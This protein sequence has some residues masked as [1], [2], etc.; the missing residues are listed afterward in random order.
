MTFL[1]LVVVVL[2]IPLS[3]EKQRN[4][5]GSGAINRKQSFLIEAVHFIGLYLY[6]AKVV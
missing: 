3:G 6:S 1:K 2:I 4:G 5:Q